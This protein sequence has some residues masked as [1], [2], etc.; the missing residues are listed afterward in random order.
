MG[1]GKA[2]PRLDAVEKVT[3]TACYTEDLLPPNVL[4][5][6]VLHSTIANGF[7]TAIHTDKA[8]TVPGVKDVVTYFDV[9]QTR[10][11]TV[12]HPRVLKS[13]RGEI[14]DRLMLTSRV[15]YYGDDVAV[16]V[17][18][19]ALT[20]QK[21]LELI[22][23]EYEEHPPLLTIQDAYDSKG[24]PIHQEYPHHNRLAEHCYEVRNNQLVT[25]DGHNVR[26][27]MEKV[28]S[29][30]NEGGDCCLVSDETYR[31]Q[32][33]QHVHIENIACFAYMDG[34]RIVVVSSTQSPHVLRCV[35]SDALSY[36]V[37]D[38]RVIKPYIGGAFGNKQEILYEPLTAFLTKRLGG[39]P[40]CILL[41]REETF[42]NTR[43]RHAMEIRIQSKLSVEAGGESFGRGVTIRSNKG[44]HASHGH[45]VTAHALDNLAH[46]YNGDFTFGQSYTIFTNL[47]ASAAM[48]GYGLPQVTFAMESHMDELAAKLGIDP[49]ELRKKHMMKPD[50]IDPFCPEPHHSNGLEQCIDKGAELIGWHKKRKEYARQNTGKLR[51]GVGMGI[52]TYKSCVYPYIL[53]N[54]GCRII[55]NENGSLI[56]HIGATE[57]GQ[58]SDT[59]FAQMASETLHIPEEKIHVVP[60]LD[61]DTTPYDPGSYASRQSYVTGSAVKKAA[62]ELKDKILAHA[63][64]LSG[65]APDELALNDQTV[66]DRSG[67][68]VLSIAEVAYHALYNRQDSQQLTAEVTYTSHHNAFAFGACFADVEVDVPLGKVKILDI[69]SVHDSGRIINPKLAEG[70]VHGGIAMGVGYALSEELLFDKTSGKPLNNNL[71]DYKVPTSMDIPPIKCEFVETYEPTGPYGNKCLGEPPVI[72][73]APAIRNAVFFATGVPVRKLPMTPQYL[74][75]SFMEYGLIPKIEV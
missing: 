33:V 4:Y 11:T 66:V 25:M 41:S 58:G 74:V 60:T 16:V 15:R 13:E 2:L 26:S 1:I 10:F 7:V 6:K 72:A 52:F 14:E 51:R 37:G 30:G 54:A 67:K 17:A 47:P 73:T 20:A 75:E 3:G 36:P 56:V 24:I 44:S 35:I 42:V 28:F 39:K 5:A 71:L 69:V 23:V 50:F 48:R 49:I 19:D 64:A 46:I 22:E 29:G 38:V 40:V 57:I 18:K 31:V 34:R 9:P 27:Q 68:R 63:A 65:R 55:L 12:A 62:V 53:E 21:A 45:A 8:K 70:Q 43:V 61:T 59:V 32:M